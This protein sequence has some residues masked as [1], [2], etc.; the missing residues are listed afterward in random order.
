MGGKGI[1]G[2]GVKGKSVKGKDSSFPFKWSSIV[3][4]IFIVKFHM[5]NRQFKKRGKQVYIIKQDRIIR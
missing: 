2:K 5:Y 4:G 3:L 1:G